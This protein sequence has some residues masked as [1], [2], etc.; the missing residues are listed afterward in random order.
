MLVTLHLL[1]SSRG[2]R[3]R[4]GPPSRRSRRSPGR[5]PRRRRRTRRLAALTLTPGK[6]RN[7]FHTLASRGSARTIEGALR[8]AEVGEDAC[9]PTWRRGLREL[10]EVGDHDLAVLELPEQRRARGHPPRLGGHVVGVVARAG[11]RRP[12]RR[13]ARWAT[14]GRR[15]GR[16]RCPS[17]GRASCWCPCTAERPRVFAVPW[18]WFAWCITTASLSVRYS[19]RVLARLVVER[20]LVELDLADRSGL[21]ALELHRLSPSSSSGRRSWPSGPGRSRPW[22][23]GTAPLMNSR[24]RSTSMRTTSRFL[25]V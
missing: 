12:C 5:R 25:V 24:L 20:P 17:G 10:A 23:P 16:G 4:S 7:D 1:R 11:V 18:R 13:R 22:G 8:R 6:F 15:R 21:I 2:R 14:C 9:A 3:G 19:T